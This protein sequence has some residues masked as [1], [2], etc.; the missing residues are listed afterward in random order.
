MGEEQRNVQTGNLKRKPGAKAPVKDGKPMNQEI[1][2][3]L[4]EMVEK[5]I[6]EEDYSIMREAFRIAYKNDIEMIEADDH[7]MVEDERFDFN[8]AF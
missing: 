6:A 3:Q 4:W 7:V 8:G 5:A 1:K 2:K